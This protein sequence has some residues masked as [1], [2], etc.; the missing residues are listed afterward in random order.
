MLVRSILQQKGAD[1]VTVE[2]SATVREAAR[3]LAEH[4]IGALV[5]APDG[6][7]ARGILSERDVVRAIAEH[8]SQALDLPVSQLMTTVLATCSLDD[9]VDTLMATMTERRVRH[10]PVLDGRRLVGIVSIGDVVK[11]RVEELQ[12]EAQTL[13]DYLETGR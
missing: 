9:G 13:H 6:E 8:G 12:V 10:L 3:S 2:E 7:Q 1:V 11:H 4:R 5:I